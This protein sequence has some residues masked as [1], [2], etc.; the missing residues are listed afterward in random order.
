M[1]LISRAA[2]LAAATLVAGTLAAVPMGAANAATP[3]LDYKCGLYGGAVQVDVK[4]V[5]DTDAPAELV[6]GTKSPVLNGT[7][8]VT[9]SG[10]WADA[11]RNLTDNVEGTAKADTLLD[12]TA[13]SSTLAIAKTAIKGT[14]GD[15]LIKAAGPLYDVTAGAAGAKHVIKAGAFVATLKF[16]KDGGEASEQT[17][18]C[19][20][21]EGVVQDLTVDTIT[22][23]PAPPAD[24]EPVVKADTKTKVKGKY[25]KSKKMIKAVVRVAGGET[26][27]TGKAKVVVKLGKKTV[28]K[29]NVKVKNGKAVAKVK[30]ITRKGKYKIV[31]TYKGDKTHKRSKGKTVV[32]VK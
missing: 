32:K 21:T 11:L 9:V 14:T 28:K 22:V 1:K 31:V 6:S 15:V 5:F 8:T 3:S 10:T 29:L 7:A 4:A 20:P 17:L 19:K 24:P 30:K 18:D 23:T 13:K 27:A 16:Q 2:G 12:T 26:K 25:V